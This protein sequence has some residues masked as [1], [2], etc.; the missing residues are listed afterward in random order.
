MKRLRYV[1]AACPRPAPADTLRTGRDGGQLASS[2]PRIAYGHR[3]EFVARV[4][5]ARRVAYLL[6]SSSCATPQIHFLRP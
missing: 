6:S 5:P 1:A 4:A 3:T 2:A